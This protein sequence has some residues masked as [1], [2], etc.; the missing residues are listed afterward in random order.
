LLQGV[1]GGGELAFELGIGALLGEELIGRERVIE[2]AL[3]RLVATEPGLQPRELRVDLASPIGIAPELGIRGGSLE[4]GD[5][6]AR[7]LD[8]KGTPSPPRRARRDR[9]ADRCGRSSTAS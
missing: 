2:L 4:L 9:P 7:A 5:L 8:V 1:D 6:R 3:Q